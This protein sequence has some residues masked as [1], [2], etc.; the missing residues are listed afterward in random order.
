MVSR[1]IVS[2]IAFQSSAEISTAED[3][4]PA[5][6]IGSC[7]SAAWSISRYRLARAA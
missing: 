6:R 3:R 4:L 2:W 5:I 1:C 7:D